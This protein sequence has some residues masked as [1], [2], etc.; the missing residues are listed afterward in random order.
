MYHSKRPEEIRVVFDCSAQLQGMSLNSELQQ[1][2]DLT[3]N[4]VGKLLLFRQDPVA[5][6]GD[7]QSCFTKCVFMCRIVT[8]CGFS[9]GPVEIL[10]RV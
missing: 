7:V 10:L 3:N 4:M 1:G 9:G 8:F 6:M 5:V 2:P